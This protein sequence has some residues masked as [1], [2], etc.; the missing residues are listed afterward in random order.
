MIG[1]LWWTELP[2]RA[3]RLSPAL[4]GALS[5]GAYLTAWPV[6]AAWAPPVAF[7]LGLLLGGR[8]PES[9]AV[10][11]SSI[12]MMALLVIVGGFGAA[13]GAC[14]S[15]GYAIGDFV[16]RTHPAPAGQ[17]AYGLYA[18]A[19]VRAPLA[20]AYVLVV[21][22]TMLVPLGSRQL[23]ASAALGLRPGNPNA[24]V[25]RSVAHAAL[26]ALVTGAWLIIAP[27]LS[28][29]LFSWQGI[30]P[31]A[32]IVPPRYVAWM[33]AL[34]AAG[35]ALTRDRIE[36]LVSTRAAY[37]QWQADMQRNQP[38]PARPHRA[39]LPV[40]V[41]LL[42]G[43]A[44][45]TF[46]LSGLLSSSVDA[47]LLGSVLLLVAVFRRVVSHAKAWVALVSRVPV[48]VR[49]AAS[50]VVGLVVSLAIIGALWHQLPVF[51]REACAMGGS[52]CVTA[53]FLAGGGLGNA[54]PAATGRAVAAVGRA[55]T[56]IRDAPRALPVSP[57]SSLVSVPPA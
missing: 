44:L 3:R 18:L 54:V 23:S 41:S 16:W 24:G 53:L 48:A 21:G 11:T 14:L 50:A 22:L 55:P 49:F 15:F 4:F 42:I 2:R 25:I 36:S 20:I 43:A 51:L 46:L 35:V 37:A 12:V 56:G 27:T 29:P 9:W 26:A 13:L 6:A 7:V 10:P 30:S 17:A 52:L 40:E 5:D 32:D 1:A 19:H 45:G 31:P 47:V 33:V 8:R 57:S 28:H 39:F 38:T 34:L